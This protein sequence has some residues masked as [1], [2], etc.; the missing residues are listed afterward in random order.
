MLF[1][2]GA[3]DR[4]TPAAKARELAARLPGA[5]AV[6]LPRVGHMMMLEDPSGTLDALKTIL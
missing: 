5:R 3:D 4:M 6:T 2:L 1:L